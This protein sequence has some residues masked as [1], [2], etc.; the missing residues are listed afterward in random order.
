MTTESVW[1]LWIVG[2]KGT[3]WNHTCMLCAGRVQSQYEVT[4]TARTLTLMS[5][6]TRE[7]E[8][9]SKE[10]T[11]AREQRRGGGV[12]PTQQKE[13]WGQIAKSTALQQRG[14]KWMTIVRSNRG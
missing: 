10:E 6:S 11:A 4:G 3:I 5:K 13:K 1:A 7:G 12:H 8:D 14:T 2:G 9:G